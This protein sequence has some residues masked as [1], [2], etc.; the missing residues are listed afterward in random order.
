MTNVLA[1]IGRKI[2]LFHQAFVDAVMQIPDNLSVILKNFFSHD[3]VF[4]D[5]FLREFYHSGIKCLPIAAL[6]SGLLSIAVMRGIPYLL[7]IFGLNAEAIYGNI[8][9][10]LLFDIAPLFSGIIVAV[11]A[12]VYITMRLAQMK[13]NGEVDLLEI[14]GVDPSMYLGSMT[15][16]AGILVIPFVSLYFIFIML[17]I[18]LLY[19]FVINSGIMVTQFI[20]CIIPYLTLKNF[21]HFFLKTMFIGLLVYFFSV[22]N[23][24]A[25][26]RNSGEIVSRTIN[27]ILFSEVTVILVNV[28]A[29]IFW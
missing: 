16:L 17:I 19:L 23:G 11:R 14:M 24:L 18:S 20:F 21:G 9:K 3:S 15:I 26:K 29:L 6:T 2:R 22:Y 25:A 10:L 8:F 7:E 13:I 1:K 28:L 5:N 12:S 4:R 27:S